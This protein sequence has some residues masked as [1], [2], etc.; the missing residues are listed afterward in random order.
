VQALAGMAEGFLG[1]LRLSGR[2]AVERDGQVVDPVQPA[3]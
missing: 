2:E 3:R 1:G